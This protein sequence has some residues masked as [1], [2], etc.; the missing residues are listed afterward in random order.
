MPRA[1]PASVDREPTEP[2]FLRLLEGLR[3]VVSMADLTIR[4]G[5]SANTIKRWVR[6]QGFP[7]PIAIAG[8]RRWLLLDVVGWL[9]T[10]A[11]I[12]R[13]EEH[14]DKMRR[15]RHGARHAHA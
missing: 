9:R 3:P 12:R 14:L 7:V 6:V 5:V 15:A 1:R 2:P 13:R 4:L 10:A 8:N 11:F